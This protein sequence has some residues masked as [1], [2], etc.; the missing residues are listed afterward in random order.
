MGAQYKPK[1]SKWVFLVG[2]L[3]VS[4]LVYATLIYKVGRYGP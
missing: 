4:A 3:L 1:I 2:M